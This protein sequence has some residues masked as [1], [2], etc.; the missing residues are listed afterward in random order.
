MDG[1]TAPELY[2]IW[3]EAKTYIEHGHYDKAIETYKYVLIRY[4][5][6]DIALER[7]QKLCVDIIPHSIEA[8][9][10]Q[11]ETRESRLTKLREK[12]EWFMRSFLDSAPEYY[13]FQNN[14]FVS[15]DG[16]M[17]SILDS[18]CIARKRL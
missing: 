14:T 5:D 13:Y 6:N 3:N 1:G 7:I 12:S 16:F 2:T 18:V 10:S 17:A 8:Y 4:S 11:Q 9:V 15:Y